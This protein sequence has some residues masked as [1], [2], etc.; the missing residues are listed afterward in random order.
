[1][2]LTFL[3]KDSQPNNSPTLYA[4][5]DESFV[6]QGWIVSDAAALAAAN[7]ADDETVVEIP[8]KLLRYLERAGIVG[9]VMN[10]VPPIVYVTTEGNYIVKGRQV[11]DPETLGR[12]HIPDN[13]SCVLVT[14]SS[15]LALVEV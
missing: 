14:R 8:A 12:M 5:D 7:L 4:T 1:M 15:V 13:E 3:G 6:M 11:H 9:G 2:H 10:L